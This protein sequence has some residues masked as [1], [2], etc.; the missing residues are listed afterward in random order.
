MLGFELRK[1]EKEMECH[2]VFFSLFLLEKNYIRNK[3][4]VKN[5]VL[6]VK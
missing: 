2:L 5:E 6:V 4:R 3:T 1:E